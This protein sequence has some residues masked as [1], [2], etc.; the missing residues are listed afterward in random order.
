M[1]RKEKKLKLMTNHEKLSDQNRK[2][3]TAKVIAISYLIKLLT[4]NQQNVSPEMNLGNKFWVSAIDL[5]DLVQKIIKQADSKTISQKDI[6]RFS[7]T[8]L[9]LYKQMKI[10]KENEFLVKALFESLAYMILS[11]DVLTKVCSVTKFALTSLR[12]ISNS[13]EEEQSSPIDKKAEK[14]AIENLHDE[15]NTFTDNEP[16]FNLDDIAFSLI[17]NMP[18][19]QEKEGDKAVANAAEEDPIREEAPS[20]DSFSEI[21]ELKD[22]PQAK[23]REKN[24]DQIDKDLSAAEDITSEIFSID[25]FKN[26]KVEYCNVSVNTVI[27][28]INN[29]NNANEK[30]KLVIERILFNAYII[31]YLKD[32]VHR[33]LVTLT[34]LLKATYIIDTVWQQKQIR[35]R[36]RTLFLKLTDKIKSNLSTIVDC[37]DDSSREELLKHFSK[38]G[39]N[40]KLKNAV[41]DFDI[42]PPTEIEKLKLQSHIIPEYKQSASENLN[43]RGSV[44]LA[45]SDNTASLPVD[46]GVSSIWLNSNTLASIRKI[47]IGSQVS[48]S[49]IGTLNQNSV[50]NK[51]VSGNGKPFYDSKRKLDASQ[52]IFNYKAGEKSK[53]KKTSHSVDSK[54]CKQKVKVKDDWLNDITEIETV[55]DIAEYEEDRESLEEFKEDKLRYPLLARLTRHFQSECIRIMTEINRTNDKGDIIDKRGEPIEKQTYKFLFLVDN[56]G[57]MNGDKMTM[58]LNT[59]VVLLESLKRMEYETAVVRFGGEK[60]QVTLKHFDEKMDQHRGQLIIESFDSSESTL[61]ADAIRYVAE[62]VE[63]YGQ[64]CQQNEHRFILLITDGIWEQRKKSLYDEF[65]AKARARPLIITTHP[66][67]DKSLQHYNTSVAMATKI[68]NDIAPNMWSEMDPSEDFGTQIT[69]IAQI[70]DNNLRDI[71]KKLDTQNTPGFSTIKVSCLVIKLEF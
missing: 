36:F 31:K 62:T 39:I 27:T 66:K 23:I 20:F 58:A 46:F 16:K 9:T 64:S 22:E 17:S 32:H 30:I 19:F 1:R 43:M 38:I 45:L 24:L 60:S 51:N 54:L 69:K 40:L 41:Y 3:K 4:L 56:S 53:Q 15:V 13:Q 12:F 52:I 70:I 65:I 59:L 29:C 28:V 67:K 14:L 11:Q 71:V 7:N 47:E 21:Q 35:G 55:R 44:Y 61:A 68:L 8:L 5:Y 50:G 26:F 57:S 48:I 49:S 34:E 37:V 25:L 2:S 10:Q 18:E 63:L 42:T 6:I 33:L